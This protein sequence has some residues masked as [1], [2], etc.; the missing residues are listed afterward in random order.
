MPDPDI[1]KKQKQ[2]DKKEVFTTQQRTA[3]PFATAAATIPAFLL[4]VSPSWV[5]MRLEDF[6]YAF[7]P[8]H[9]PLSKVVSGESGSSFRESKRR[10]NSEFYSVYQ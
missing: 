4:L 9:F 1:K 3:A 10:M 6:V 2:D 8:P 7:I 5:F